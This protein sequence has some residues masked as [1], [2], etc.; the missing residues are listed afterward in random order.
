MRI[1]HIIIGPTATGKTACSVS[2]AQ[3]LGAPVIV[4]DR[5]QV[6]RDLATGTGR[7][8]PEELH[9]T[10][11]FYLA[12]RCA[13]DGDFPAAD[14]YVSLLLHL[15]RLARRDV[16][17]ILEGGSLSLLQ[18]ISERFEIRRHACTLRCTTFDTAEHYRGL[19]LSRV[20]EMLAPAAPGRASILVELASAWKHEDSRQFVRT[21]CGYDA[22]LEWCEEEAVDP[23]SIEAHLTDPRA[24]RAIE[25]RIL[26]AHFAYGESQRRALTEI[27]DRFESMGARR[28]RSKDA[29]E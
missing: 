17:V 1:L 24:L 18:Q 14:A 16:P 26:A 23:A 7:P 28:L 19:L 5:L 11:R 15:E 12:D 8:S 27:S 9:G 29:M 21:I 10:E 22:V 4:L 13:R 2:M 3:Q 20:A 6:Y 25:A